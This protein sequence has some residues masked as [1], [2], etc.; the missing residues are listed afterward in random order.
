MLANLTLRIL[1][2]VSTSANTPTVIEV[3]PTIKLDDAK[4]D[5]SSTVSIIS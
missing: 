2:A 5:A 3:L 1:L 4:S